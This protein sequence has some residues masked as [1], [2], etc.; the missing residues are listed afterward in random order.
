MVKKTGKSLENL[1]EETVGE[2]I[3]GQLTSV[4]VLNDIAK[5]VT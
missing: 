2:T 3:I 5:K 4:E 1:Q